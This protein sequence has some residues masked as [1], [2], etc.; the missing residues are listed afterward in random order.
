[1][2]ICVVCSRCGEA[3]AETTVLIVYRQGG[4]EDGINYAYDVTALADNSVVLTGTTNGDF[5]GAG[6]HMGGETDF[7]AIKLTATGV[8]E[9]TW[10]VSERLTQQ[11]VAVTTATAR[12]PGLSLGPKCRDASWLEAQL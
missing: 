9:W 12:R 4:H 7:V 1:M 10:Q 8:E 5:A 2:K 6:A 3:A 11:N